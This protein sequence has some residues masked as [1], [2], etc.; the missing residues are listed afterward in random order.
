MSNNIVSI[1]PF[2]ILITVANVLILFGILRHFLFKPVNEVLAKRAAAIKE[3]N[4][5][6]E[7]ARRDAETARQDYENK[8]SGIK[9]MEEEAV[10]DSQKKASEEY[11]RILTDARTKAS[12]IVSEAEKK[13]EMEQKNRMAEADQRLCD[14]V[15]KAAAKIAATENSQALNSGLYDEFISKAGEDSGK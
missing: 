6:A 9:T 4:D 8:V 13:A 12:A 5:K 2:S 3:E 15:A 10:K 7:A 1:D 14:I 11:D